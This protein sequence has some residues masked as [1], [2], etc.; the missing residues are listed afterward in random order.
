MGSLIKV[1]NL[2]DI[3]TFY[4][5]IINRKDLKTLACMSCIYHIKK[6]V[7]KTY[8]LCMVLITYHRC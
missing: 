7:F 5:V 4:N 1:N 6:I 2:H 8:N 3:L